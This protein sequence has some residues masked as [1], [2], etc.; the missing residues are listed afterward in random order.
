MSYVPTFPFLGGRL[1]LGVGARFSAFL[2]GSG[3]RFEDVDAPGAIHRLTVDGVRIY[4]LNAMFIATVRLAA[5]LEAGFDIDLAGAALGPAVNGAYPSA[6]PAFAGT[7]RAR[8]RRWN[9]LLLGDR[10]L[11]QLDSQFFLA[12]WPGHFGLRAG[13]SHEI[14]EYVTSRRLDGGNDRFRSAATRAFLAVA[15]RI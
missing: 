9:L 7:Q 15:W 5:G 2:S 3:A 1:R 13:L 11:G 4:A 14:T 6:D 12:W 10:D 8:P